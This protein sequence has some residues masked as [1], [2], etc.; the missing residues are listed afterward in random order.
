MKDQTYIVCQ[1]QSHFPQPSP[2]LK[3]WLGLW[4]T[5]QIVGRPPREAALQ[6]LKALIWVSRGVSGI[7]VST[8][9][10]DSSSHCFTPPALLHLQYLLCWK[11]AL[12]GNWIRELSTK[13]KLGQLFLSTIYCG[14]KIFFGKGSSNAENHVKLF[15]LKVPK[16]WRYCITI[17]CV[18]LC[19]KMYVLFNFLE[20]K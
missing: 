8:G 5:Q 1:I 17:W 2:C 18:S 12:E 15:V 10:G 7:S 13:T 19:N 6:Q 16:T 14:L 3:L 4:L 11:S 20:V 9:A